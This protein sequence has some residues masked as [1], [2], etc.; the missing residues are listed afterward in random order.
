MVYYMRM[1]VTKAWTQDENDV[2]FFYNGNVELRQ[3][4]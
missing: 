2:D 4:L 3:D 1:N